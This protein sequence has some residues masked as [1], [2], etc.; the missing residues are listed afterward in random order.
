MRPGNSILPGEKRSVPC[1]MEL[2]GLE[3]MLTG[4]RV[5]ISGDGTCLTVS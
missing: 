1:R 5:N 4:E 2:I 3:F